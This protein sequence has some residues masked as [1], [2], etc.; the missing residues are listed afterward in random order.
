VHVASTFRWKKQLSDSGGS[1]GELSLDPESTL[2]TEVLAKAMLA[3]A[4]R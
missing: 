2:A 3:Q 1:L 4:V